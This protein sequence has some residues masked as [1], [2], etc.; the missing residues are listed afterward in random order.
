MSPGALGNGKKEVRSLSGSVGLCVEKA[1]AKGQGL[2]QAPGASIPPVHLVLSDPDLLSGKDLSP[3][4]GFMG[5]LMS[6]DC[7]AV[8]QA[9]A[10]Y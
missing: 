5:C 6:A 4:E 3:A 7:G 9:T 8:P 1:V 2:C 10:G